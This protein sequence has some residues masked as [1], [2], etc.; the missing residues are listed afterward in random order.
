MNPRHQNLFLACSSNFSSDTFQYCFLSWLAKSK[1]SVRTEWR[2]KVKL[3]K[4]QLSKSLNGHVFT[5]LVSASKSHP[6]LIYFFY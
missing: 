2:A 6:T 4:K 5:V 1:T 3:M